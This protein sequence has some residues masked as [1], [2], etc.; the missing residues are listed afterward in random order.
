MTGASA[1]VTVSCNDLHRVAVM[2]NE[3]KNGL[4]RLRSPYVLHAKAPVLKADYDRVI[5]VLKQ[6]IN[7]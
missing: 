1:T 2:R 7:P 3:R 4:H 6:A 5:R